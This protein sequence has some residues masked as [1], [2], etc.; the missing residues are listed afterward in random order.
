MRLIALLLLLQFAASNAFAREKYHLTFNVSPSLEWLHFRGDQTGA[1]LN[2]IF[3]TKPS[4]NFGFE[5]EHFLDPNFSLAIGLQ[6]QNKGFR[7]VSEYPIA[8]SDELR[9]G[10][11]IVAARYIMMPTAAHV[12]IPVGRKKFIVLGGGLNVGYLPIQTI[13]GRNFDEDA[14]Q[15]GLIPLENGRS[16]IDM[17][18]KMYLGF[19]ATAAFSMYIKSR[20]VI[21]A[22]P[23]YTN[24]LNN[25][26]SSDFRTNFVV[27]GRLNSF[28]LEFKIGYYFTDQ[29]RNQ[30]KEF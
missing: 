12:H 2:D 27:N 29:I 11:T 10:I 20:V 5:Y 21:T 9:E 13:W 23:T 6:F 30:R 1:Q 16:N 14:P 3:G 18:K 25:A 24:Q 15:G 19:N 4:Y 26:I 28:A 22:Q 7:N 8:G 17:F